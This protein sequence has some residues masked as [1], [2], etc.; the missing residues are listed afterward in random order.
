MVCSDLFASESSPRYKVLVDGPGGLSDV[1]LLAV[2]LRTGSPG[3]TAQALAQSLLDRF[4]GVSGLLYACADDF[5][6]IRGMTGINRA[7]LVSVLE[8]VRRATGEQLKQRD[9]FTSPDAVK[10]FLQLHIARLPHEVFAV[11]FL[12]AQNRLIEMEVMFRGTLTQTS[13]YPRE[14]VKR[15]L[16]HDAAAVIFSHNHPSGTTEPSKADEAL[17]VTLKQALALVDVRVLDHVV[18][19]PGMASSFAETGLI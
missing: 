10:H 5:A 3:K 17:T 14:I 11:M 2:F 15:A 18:V 9:V 19:A 8:L 1:E 12:D 4:G 13:V 16:D 7:A 6:G